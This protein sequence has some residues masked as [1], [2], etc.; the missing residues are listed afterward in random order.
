[1]GP[2]SGIALHLSTP[3]FVCFCYTNH[4][5]IL[6]GHFLGVQLRDGLVE[7]MEAVEAVPRKYLHMGGYR[8]FLGLPP[9][10][11]LASILCSFR[12]CMQSSS[13]YYA[14]GAGRMSAPPASPPKWP[15]PPGV[16]ASRA[17]RPSGRLGTLGTWT[18]TGTDARHSCTERTPVLSTRDTTPVH[19][20]PIPPGGIAIVIPRV[21]AGRG[22]A[23]P[24]RGVRAS[25]ERGSQVATTNARRNRTT[26][27][28][29]VAAA[30]VGAIDP[31]TE[32]VTA[33]ELAEHD[34]AELARAS[35]AEPGAVVSASEHG[36]GIVGCR[37][38]S[39]HP[40]ISQPDRQVKL[41]CPTCGAVARMTAS[42]LAKAGSIT[43]GDG[44][45][46]APAARRAYTPRS[47]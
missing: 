9:L 10:L 33:S 21:Y 17:N 37:H 34:A 40:V 46:F 7:G 38:G 16:A 36:C 14:V 27:A 8:R 26:V 2:S 25:I 43:C 28:D 30:Q 15:P 44:S 13:A 39:A 45:Q 1:M 18:R 19:A 3:V 47:R 42:A 5:A 12:G 35:S 31:T 23:T 11:P 6:R 29:L 32:V 24:R 4:I 20:P 22:P 41:Q